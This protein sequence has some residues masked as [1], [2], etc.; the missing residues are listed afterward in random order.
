MT[1]SKP[2]FRADHVGSLLR[3]PELREARAK[4]KRGELPAAAVT[5]IEDACIREA[6]A[7]QEA[8]GLEAV[9]D[10]EFRRDWWHL[11]FLSG[12]DGIGLKASTALKFQGVDEIPPTPT[13]TGRIRATRPNMIGHF[14]FLRSVAT[15]TAKFCIP[16]PSMA[17]MRGGTNGIP[18][19]LYPDPAEYWADLGAA[20]RATIAQLAAAGCT[21]LQIDDTTFSY[22]ADE[23][24][25][26][27]CRSNGDDPARLH[28]TY[29]DA[30]N[31]ALAGR[32]PGMT[33]TLHTCRGNFQSTWMAEQPYEAAIVE[34]MFSTA[35]DGYFME[36]DSARAGSF[37]VLRLLP[38]GK[39][40][41]LGLVT[42]KFGTLESKEALKKRIAEAAK[43][44]PL[45]NLC[46]SPQCGFASTHHGNLLS[47]EEQWWKLERV[48]EV[49]REVWG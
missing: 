39:K 35:V 8:I 42:T 33:V 34:S 15:K 37:D 3:P 23:K 5:E 16:S 29:A 36:F 14:A 6:V 44:V 4:A 21:Y 27:L 49:A 41:V 43:F 19:E 17:H 47:F 48:V 7:K 25:K 2:P 28:R 13:V 38:R 18:K 40:V 11:D 9:T 22:L 45:E 24:M 26:A 12:F 30:I 20:Y 31:L 46:L 32:P 10:G 1:T